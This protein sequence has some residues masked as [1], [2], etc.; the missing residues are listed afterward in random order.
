MNSTKR[1]VGALQVLLISPAALFLA[2]L[3]VRRLPPHA[4]EPAHTAE[5][6]A[7]WYIVRLW[8]LW[9]LLS[10]LPLI[11]LVTGLLTLLPGWDLTTGQTLARLR[12]GTALR[13]IALTRWLQQA[14]WRL[15]PFT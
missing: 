1:M 11:A 8:T 15:S 5:Q 3:V 2:A 6:I 12:T 4:A 13:T 10:A 9:V 7:M 14:S